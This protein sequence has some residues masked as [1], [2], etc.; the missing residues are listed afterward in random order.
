VY[1]GIESVASSRS[2]ATNVAVEERRLRF[3][4][5]LAR[6]AHIPTRERCTSTLQRAVHGCNRGIQ[7]LGDFRGR[8][9]KHVGQ[10][11]RGALPRR[12]VLKRRHEREADALPERG[13]FERI[14]VSRDRANIRNWLEPMRARASLELGV[15]GADG[16]LFNRTRATRTV[17]ECVEAHVRRDSVQPRSYRR[18]PFEAVEISPRTHH[19]LLH[20]ILGIGSR[21]KHAVAMAGQDGS[22]GFQ[23]RDVE[24]HPILIPPPD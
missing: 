15:Y 6:N 7:A 3:G 16:T 1:G 17:R 8:P 18:A 12:Q 11:E 2:N 9:A 21:A 23:L 24:R 10:D 22:V 19:R 13:D 4:E 20:G 14:A 5:R